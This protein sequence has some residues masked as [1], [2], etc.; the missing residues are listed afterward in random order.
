VKAYDEG[1]RHRGDHGQTEVPI[2]T[3]SSKRAIRTVA[4]IRLTRVIWIVTFT[5]LFMAALV[6]LN[7]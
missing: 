7:N 6:A 2:P 3:P 1:L 4:F 5:L